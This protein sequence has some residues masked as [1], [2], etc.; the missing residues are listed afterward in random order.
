MDALA[1]L[2]K[3]ETSAK[4]KEL[5]GEKSKSFLTTVM[6]LVSQNKQLKEA[7]PSSVY[8]AALMSAALDLPINQNLGFAYILPYKS[9]EG[10]KAQFQMG[11]KGF[12]QL[13]LRSGQFKT[14]SATPVYA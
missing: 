5:L 11:Y 9:R 2:K 7:E 6:S 14:L 10:M 3:D 13:A 12:I 4:F 8:L 1:L